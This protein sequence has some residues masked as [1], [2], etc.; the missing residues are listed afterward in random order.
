MSNVYVPNVYVPNDVLVFVVNV[1]DDAVPSA[2]MCIAQESF[3][4]SDFSGLGMIVDDLVAD[5]CY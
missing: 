5:V 2:S 1:G 4:V 3:E